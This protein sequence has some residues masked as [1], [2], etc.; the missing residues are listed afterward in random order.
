MKTLEEKRKARAKEYYLRKRQELVS[1][2]GKGS[3]ILLAHLS[4]S[5]SA[6]EG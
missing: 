3:L 6:P 1:C 5:L 4:S 2:D